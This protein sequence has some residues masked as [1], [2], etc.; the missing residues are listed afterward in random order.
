MG[1]PTTETEISNQ[2]VVPF[3]QAFVAAQ[4]Y[5]LYLKMSEKLKWFEL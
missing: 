5:F 1:S 3:S 4:D 2:L